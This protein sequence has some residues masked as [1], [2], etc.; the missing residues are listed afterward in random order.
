MRQK[1]SRRRSSGG[2]R[3][4]GVRRV[5]GVSVWVLA[6]I[7]VLFLAAGRVDMPKLW[8][9]AATLCGCFVIGGA[10]VLRVCPEIINQ[11]GERK[12]GTKGWDRVFAAGYVPMVFVLPVVAGLDVGR[13]HWSSMRASAAVMGTAVHVLAAALFAWAM[14]T[15]PH[16]ETT[17]RIQ[18]ERDHRVVKGG[19]YRFVRHPGY[20]G[21]ILLSA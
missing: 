20:V 4:V 21:G 10:I 1:A 18:S 9:F 3:R 11:R 5:I 7:V 17:V 14:T 6:Q 8:L 12:T 13:Y 2:L 19:R 15:N 16:F